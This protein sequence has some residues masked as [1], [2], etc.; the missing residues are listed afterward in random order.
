MCV[1][2]RIGVR[3][4]RQ[5]I[6]VYLRRVEQGEAFTVTDHG[7]AV[8]VLAPLPPDDDPLADL[9]AAGLVEPRK[10]GLGGLPE[11]AQ[12]RP[13]DRPLSEILREMRDEETR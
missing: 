8:A 2:E 12:P 10:G 6:S 4:V 1:M 5:N 13:G 3:E 7:R 11:P 9:V